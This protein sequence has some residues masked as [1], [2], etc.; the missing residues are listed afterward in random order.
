MLSKA[1]DKPEVRSQMLAT[2]VPD[3]LTMALPTQ[4]LVCSLQV[5]AGS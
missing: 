4:E 5:A 1:S 3:Y 2:L